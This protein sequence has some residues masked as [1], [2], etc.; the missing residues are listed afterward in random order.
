MKS[1]LKKRNVQMD[2]VETH[3]E[4]AA[5]STTVN[6]V[7]LKKAVHIYTQKKLLDRQK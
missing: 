3:I 7:A 4:K 1:T 6:E 5:N 2:T